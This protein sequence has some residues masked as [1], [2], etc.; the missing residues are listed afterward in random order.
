V[1]EALNGKT[2][3]VSLGAR[4]VVTLHNTYWQFAA[5]SASP[6]LTQAGSPKTVPG[7]SCVPGAGCG[8]VVAT[9]RALSRGVDVVKA[10][11]HLCGEMLI[12]QPKQRT[13]RVLIKVV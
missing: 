11:R 10:T 1:D 7:G 5:L 9:Y 4:V 2:V 12:C 3:T 8:T 13:F 6:V